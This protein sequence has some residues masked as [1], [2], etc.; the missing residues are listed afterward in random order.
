MEEKPMK[1]ILL[2][3]LKNRGKKDDI[4]EVPAGFGN[5]LL[6]SKQAIEATSENVASI[7]SQKQK[8]KDTAQAELE[9]M[10]ALKTQLDNQ[11]IKLAVK[12]GEK[13]K[14]YGKLTTKHLADALNTQL[15]FDVD[16]RKIQLPDKIEALG[17][18]TIEVKLHKEVLA[19][20][21]LQVVE[22]V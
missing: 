4:I 7:E 14:L 8:L 3:D 19:S 20:F 1:V 13:G 9:A 22:A 2:K 21:E 16:K 5:Y 10:K 18:Y 11:V 12:M 15:G 6:T 17:S